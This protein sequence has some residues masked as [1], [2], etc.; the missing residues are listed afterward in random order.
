[1]I[2]LR[3]REGCLVVI[4]VA[5]VA[6]IFTVAFSAQTLRVARRKHRRHVQ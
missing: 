2:V 3:C 4:A 5:V 6:I 1:M